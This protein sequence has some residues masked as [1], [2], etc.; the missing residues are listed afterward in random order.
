MSLSFR[1][2]NIDEA[3]IAGP[4]ITMEAHSDDDY[5]NNPNSKSTFLFKI[6]TNVIN[7][8]AAAL[9]NVAIPNVIPNITAA[10]NRLVGSIN[11]NPFDFLIEDGPSNAG[12][13]VLNSLPIYTAT[14]YAAKNEQIIA[15]VGA[16]LTLTWGGDLDTYI[17]EDAGFQ[18]R[19]AN[20]S[21]GDFI[22]NTDLS[23]ACKVFGLIPNSGNWVVTTGTTRSPPRTPLLQKTNNIFIN[24]KG[25]NMPT[26]NQG[27]YQNFSRTQFKVKMDEDAGFFINYNKMDEDNTVYW[28]NANNS[29]GTFTV[30]LE[31]DNGNEID[32]GGSNYTITIK[33]LRIKT[34]TFSFPN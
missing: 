25:S 14:Q 17:E 30:S 15:T 21:G 6:G 4:S 32:I 20:A 7:Y 27:S 22:I 23:T 13:T 24:L 28:N 12:V 2:V 5:V 8:G 16:G 31:D 33:L 11:G 9:E 29:T 10:N 26:T 19:F 1:N 34:N 18:F 3:L